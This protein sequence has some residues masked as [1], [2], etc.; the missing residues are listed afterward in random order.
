M[1]LPDRID[2]YGNKYWYKPGTT[3]RHR[4]DGPAV[5][6]AGGTKYWYQNDVLH[7]LGGP[8]IEYS[9]GTLFWYKEGKYHREDGPALIYNYNTEYWYINNK[10]ID[11]QSQEEFEKLMKLKAFW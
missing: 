8:A 10:K 9:D 1:S 6:L 3:I 2:Y 7:R 5:E 11:C 4:L